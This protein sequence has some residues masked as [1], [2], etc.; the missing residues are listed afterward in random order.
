MNIWLSMHLNCPEVLLALGLVLIL[1]VD[2][3]L[4]QGYKAAS[5]YLSELLLL[6]LGVVFIKEWHYAPQ[7]FFSGHYSFDALAVGLKGMLVLFTFLVFAYAKKERAFGVYLSEFFILGLL[8]LLGAMVLASAASLISLY[9]GLELLSL[10]LYA[11]VALKRDS[12]LATEA[13]MKYFVMGALASALL[14]FGFSLLYGLTGS[15]FLAQ[16]ANTMNG[17]MM[18]N[19]AFLLALSLV[20]VAAAFKLGVFPFHMWV[21]DV[22]QGAP[23]SVVAFLSSVAKIGGFVL[24]VRVLKDGFGILHFMAEQILI[25]LGVFSLIVGNLVAL[26]QK[27]IKRLLGYSAVANMGIVFIALGLSTD[28]ALASS[29]F[30]LLSYAF[31]SVAMLGLLIVVAPELEMIEQLKGLNQNRPVVAFLLLL[32]LLSLVG[33]PPLLGFDAKLLVIM[34]LL[35]QG[36]MALSFLIIIMSVIAAAYYLQIVKALYFDQPVPVNHV[37]TS[38]LGFIF[39]SINALALLGFGLFPSGLI[40]LTRSFFG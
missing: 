32:V 24:L 28:V 37:K 22:Y 7:V 11:M 40:M 26:T 12:S 4:P 8:S 2:V 29:V 9:L 18:V 31:M 15:I 35:H 16:I 27:N 30:Y 25:T 36:H 10:P 19:P 38:G 21:P 23:L 13:A 3:F 6:T 1:L 33:I 34:A 5:F 20:V 17:F 14:L 39:A